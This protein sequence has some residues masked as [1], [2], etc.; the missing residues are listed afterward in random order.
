L[1]FMVLMVPG[2]LLSNILILLSIAGWC[3]ALVF[4]VYIIGSNANTP[5]LSARM[6]EICISFLLY[7][8]LLGAARYLA[9]SCATFHWNLR[10]WRIGQ[11][12]AD[13]G[14]Q[15]SLALFYVFSCKYHLDVLRAFV[16]LCTNVLVTGV[17][18]V[19]NLLSSMCFGV[20]LHT[21]WLL[22]RT[23]ARERETISGVHGTRC[24]FMLPRRRPRER[25]TVGDVPL[26]PIVP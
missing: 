11:K 18:I 26:L 3:S 1:L 7:V 8:Y 17:C 21:W 4:G 20:A 16:V 13:K 10:R 19:V 23:I 15:E 5:T 22:N 2:L 24:T 12:Q 6:V 14:L 9:Y 25:A